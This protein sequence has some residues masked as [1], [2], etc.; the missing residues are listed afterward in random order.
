MIGARGLS[1]RISTL[2][3]VLFAFSTPALASSTCSQ[4][5]GPHSSGQASLA[6][7]IG[8]PSWTVRAET[9]SYED[10]SAQ[11]SRDGYEL[12]SLKTPSPEAQEAFFKSVVARFGRGSRYELAPYGDTWYFVYRMEITI[13]DGAK[14][15]PP[16]QIFVNRS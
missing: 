4:L 5:L 11:Y 15:E 13:V 16:A 6:R 3:A 1:L 7:L 2:L 9:P 8:Q 14:G 12:I 10:Y